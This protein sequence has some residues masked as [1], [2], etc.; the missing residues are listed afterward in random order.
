M[1]GLHLRPSGRNAL[2]T[3]APAATQNLATRPRRHPLTEAMAPGALEIAWLKGPLHGSL[4]L[5]MDLG[6]SAA[7]R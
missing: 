6:L 3:L 5:H 1:D 4:S 2:A 7:K